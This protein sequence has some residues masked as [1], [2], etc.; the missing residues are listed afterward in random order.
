MEAHSMDAW[1][2]DDNLKDR[3]RVA[4]PKNLEERCA[5][6]KTCLTKLA[7][8]IPPLIDDLAD[9]TEIAYTAW[10]DRLYVMDRSWSA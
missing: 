8:E 5:L 3:I 7:L 9:G 2:D 1:Q 6:A 4:T 10:P